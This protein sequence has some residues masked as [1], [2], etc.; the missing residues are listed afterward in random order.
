MNGTA[1][2]PVRIVRPAALRIEMLALPS[3]G[4]V[5]F[6]GMCPAARSV[7]LFGGGGRLPLSMKRPRPQAAGPM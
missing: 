2:M 1:P 6:T 7:P 3:R 4:I 5:N